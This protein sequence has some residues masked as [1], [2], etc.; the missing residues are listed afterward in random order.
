MNARNHGMAV[1][2]V[3]TFRP[4]TNPRHKRRAVATRFGGTLSGVEYKGAS[5]TMASLQGADL[6]QARGLAVPQVK[7]AKNWESAVYSDELKEL[8]LPPDN[9]ERVFKLFPAIYNSDG[10]RKPR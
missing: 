10:T 6:R 7:E 5:L 4:F 9:N 2:A 1:Y 8:G 3:G